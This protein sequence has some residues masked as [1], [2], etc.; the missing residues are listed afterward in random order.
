MK[1]TKKTVD[2]LKAGQQLSDSELRGF[3]A[4]CLPSGVT[5]FSFR[6]YNTAGK[7]HELPIGLHGTLTVDQARGLAQRYAGQVAGGDDPAADRK[8]EKAR[9]VYTVN[10]VIDERVKFM[11]RNGNRSVDKVARVFDVHVRP[12]IGSVVIHDLERGQVADMLKKIA[13]Q[14]PQAARGVRANLNAAFEW[15]REQDS[16]FNQIVM[17]S[18]KSIAKPTRRER[19]LE[20]DELRDIWQALD[21]ERFTDSFPAL[22]RTLLL[23]GCRRT[24]VSDMHADEIDGDIW[25]IPAARCKG[26]RDHAVPL[27]PAIAAAL[28]KVDRGFVFA[29]ERRSDQPFSAFSNTKRLLDRVIAE[30]RTAE[31]RKPM[32]AWR[33]HDLRRTARTCWTSIGIASDVAEAMLGHV[34]PGITAVYNRHN[35]AAEKSAGLERWAAYLDN[36]VRSSPDRVVALPPKLRKVRR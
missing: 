35:Y 3:R 20:L 34:Q 9:G 2:A 5:T 15:H 28:P 32:P 16:R 18:M 14:F 23:T 22:I 8:T 7:R 21:D 12:A 31:A 27:I 19:A 36:V 10:A 33:L 4:R 11:R 29:G 1:I 17:P 26:G 30:R 24:E 6:Y 13:A 25:T